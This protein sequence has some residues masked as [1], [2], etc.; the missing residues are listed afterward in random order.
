VAVKG[1]SF[2]NVEV[3]DVNNDSNPDMVVAY[4]GGSSS[5]IGSVAQSGYFVLLGNGKGG[6]QAKFTGYG[7]FV[8]QVKLVDMNGD[9]MLDMA[10]DDGYQTG[11]LICVTC[12][13][14]I[15]VL[16]GN[17]DGTF[18]TTAAHHVLDG[19]RIGGLVLG[20]YDVDGRQ[21]LTLLSRGQRDDA[22]GG[23]VPDSEGILLLKGRGDF[24]FEEPVLIAGGTTATNAQ[25][26]DFNG[27]GL[28]DL[29]F[30]L[31]TSFQDVPTYYGLVALPNLGGGSFGQPLNF[32]E[33]QADTN[34][35]LGDFNGDGAPDVLVAPYGPGFPSIVYLNKG[36]STLSLTANPT[37]ANQ[38]DS[39]DLQATL[40]VLPRRRR[41][42][43]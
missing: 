23:L 5:C 36:G 30:G 34:T 21:D 12:P 42:E 32:L 22:D 20:D 16:H 29:V 1:C 24:T 18:D 6:F 17:G 3:G 37:T 10:V 43:A 28:P 13:T 14:P 40:S 8:S 38:G 7:E 15:T 26:A 11:H 31:D 33:P 2:G 39:I 25:Y 19:W 9:G 27:D 4:N 35:L 41:L